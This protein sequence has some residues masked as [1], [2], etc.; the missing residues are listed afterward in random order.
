[1]YVGTISLRAVVV[2]WVVLCLAG[3]Y[4]YRLTPVGPDHEPIPPAT[5][6]ESVTVWSFGWGLVSQPLIRPANCQGNGTAE[7]TTTTNFGFAL[8]TVV[9]LG[10]VAPLEV[11]WRCA[12]DAPL[13]TDVF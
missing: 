1:M 11:E 10:V 13:A 12:T 7:V 4:H 5:E 9:S 8:L 2:A 3:C 6:P